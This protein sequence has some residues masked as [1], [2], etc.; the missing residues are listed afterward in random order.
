[1]LA[2]MLH[3]T[4][5]VCGHRYEYSF[6]LKPS[7]LVC[8][9]DTIQMLI[10]FTWLLWVGCTVKVAAQHVWWWRVKKE[11]AMDWIGT[12]EGTR[13]DPSREPAPATSMNDTS[14]T[15]SER[16]RPISE[17]RRISTSVLENE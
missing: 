4:G 15:E 17:R 5:R 14:Y 13:A 16:S 12:R 9:F 11:G 8:L 6:V 10:E 7:I 2:V 3:N 1:M